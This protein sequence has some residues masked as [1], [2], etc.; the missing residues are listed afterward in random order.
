MS[1][2]FFFLIA[3]GYSVESLWHLIYRT[4]IG[5]WWSSVKLQLTLSLNAVSEGGL[6]KA[7]YL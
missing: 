5:A 1:L 2:L 3:L 7:V 6:G 4:L